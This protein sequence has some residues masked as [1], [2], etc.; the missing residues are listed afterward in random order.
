MDEPQRTY[1]KRLLGLG[2]HFSLGLM[3]KAH[4]LPHQAAAAEPRGQPP[5]QAGPPI[6]AAAAAASAGMQ[7]A[8][9]PAQL[10]VGQGGHLPGVPGAQSAGWFA[11][12]CIA[13]A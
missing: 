5:L 9:L 2:L 4:A 12:C 13:S 8:A 11:V 3:H 10:A 6:A 7:A 1:R